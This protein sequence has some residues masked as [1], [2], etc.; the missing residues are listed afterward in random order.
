MLC[1]PLPHSPTI[2]H[3]LERHQGRLSFTLHMAGI[4]LTLLGALLL[5]VSL[6]T[7]SLATGALAVALFVAGYALQFLG[8]YWEG[9]DPGE[10]ILLKRRLGMPYVEFA[11]TH[12]PRRRMA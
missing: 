11:P 8:H 7:F 12:R 9:T 4:P 10:V 6:A 3:W 1:P 5:P 2:Q